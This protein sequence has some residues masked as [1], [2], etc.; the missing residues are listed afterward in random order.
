MIQVVKARISERFA[1]FCHLIYIAAFAAVFGTFARGRLSW[2]V[3]FLLGSLRPW[4]QLEDRLAPATFVVTT[5]CRLPE[6]VR[7]GRPSRA[8]TRRPGPMPSSSIIPGGVASHTINLASALPAITGTVAIK[9]QTQ[10]GFVASPLI[11]LNGT[12]AGVGAHGLVVNAAAAGTVIRGLTIN[13]FDGDGVRIQASNCRVVTCF[14]GTDDTSTVGSGNGGNGVHI[15]GGADG[16]TVGGNVNGLGNLISGNDG[17]GVLIEGA[18]TTGN[19]VQ[20]NF[21]GT[22]ASGA[23]ALPTVN[24]VAIRFGAQRN[25]VGGTSASA[26]NVISGNGSYG[27]SCGV[28]DERQRRPGELHRHRPDRHPGPRQRVQRRLHR[29]RRQ[30]KHHRRNGCRRPQRHLGE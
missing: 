13:R 11:E 17:N 21:I 18:G 10:P 26:R 14:I 9:G 22:A 7:C 1:R 8:P 6:R 29:R 24:G 15:L 25:I 4:L 16:V 19:K 12:G 20:G 2:F 3:P 27:V 28:R 23:S 30:R 5:D